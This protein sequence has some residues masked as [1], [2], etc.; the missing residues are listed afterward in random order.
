MP[1]SQYRPKLRI[2]SGYL[3]HPCLWIAPLIRRSAR[4]QAGIRVAFLKLGDYEF[5]LDECV[6]L[7]FRNNCLHTDWHRPWNSHRVGSHGYGTPVEVQ[8]GLVNS[9]HTYNYTCPNHLGYGPECNAQ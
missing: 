1:T 4:E 9:L 6:S 8:V 3:M 5:C 2:P 7:S